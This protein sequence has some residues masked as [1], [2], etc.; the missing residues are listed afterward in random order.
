MAKGIKI[1]ERKVIVV[2]EY[3]FYSIDVR[4]Q[5][6]SANFIYHVFSLFIMQKTIFFAQKVN[7]Q[8]HV[9]SLSF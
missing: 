3:R 9:K 6:K 7:V 2:V 5:E 1:E 4:D 8:P